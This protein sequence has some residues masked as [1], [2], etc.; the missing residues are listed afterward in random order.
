M[1][2]VPIEILKGVRESELGKKYIDDPL[3]KKDIWSLTELGYSEE[4]CTIQQI[5]CIYFN[6]FALEWLKLLAKLTTKAR[7]RQRHAPSGVVMTVRV[8][9]QLDN[10]L[11]A[12]TCLQPDNLTSDLLQQFIT[13][14]GYSNRVRILAY[15]I[16]LWSEENW[17]NLKFIPPRVK[18]KNPKIEVIPEEVLYQVYEKFDLLPPPLERLLR[19]QL[20]LGCRIGDIL[21]MPRY[22]LKQEADQWFLLRWIEKVK[23]WQFYRVHPL[24]A[25]LVREQQKF[26]NEKFEDTDFD[27]LFCWLS[28]KNSDTKRVS[29]NSEGQFV[30]GFLRFTV[31]PVYRPQLLS[32]QSI[33]RWLKA[34]SEIANLKD[35]YGNHFVLAS[36]MFRRTKASIMAY[37]EAEDE[38][39]ATVLGHTSLDMLPHY[40]KRSLERL[41]KEANSKGYVDMYGRVTT[42]KPQKRRYERLADLLKVS[43]PLGECHRPSMLGD[44]QYRYACLSCNHHR[45]TLEDRFKLESDRE[46]LQEE[47]KQAQEAG[48]VRRETEINRLIGLIHSRLNGLDELKAMLEKADV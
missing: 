18:R 26:L 10:F 19:L 17:L 21:K 9:C 11:V 36:H 31:K 28:V 6:K 16:R 34:F 37:C 30:K 35:K 29:L 44:C 25:E 14:S 24:I 46:Q 42:F 40:R 1:T 39:I 41:E 8:L 5:R 15:A 48:L 43:T 23:K 32:Q 7:V 13:G 33:N 38:Y 4:D 20:A 2:V 3:L 27:K 22:C 47:L 12:Q 45:V